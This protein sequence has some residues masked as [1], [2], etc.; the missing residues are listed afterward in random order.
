M[1]RYTNEQIVKALKHTKGMLY[2]A[3]KHLGCNHETISL[4]AKVCPKVAAEIRIQRGEFVDK[5]E[6]KL[7][8]AVNNDEPW[9]ILNTLKTLG[10]DRG[11]VERTEQTGKD[12][13]AIQ[14]D[15]EHKFTIDE[16]R[17]LPLEQ[18][19]RLLRGPDPL[20]ITDRSERDGTV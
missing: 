2:L 17:R 7:M 4:R 15:H 6:L 14:H 13:E 16:F 19:L 9:A 11:Y 12:G 5:A 20:P 1:P 3:A 18:R 8:N 10:K